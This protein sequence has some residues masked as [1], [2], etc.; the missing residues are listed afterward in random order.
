VLSLHDHAQG[1]CPLLGPALYVWVQGCP[2]RCPGC[3]NPGTL[4]FGRGRELPLESVVEAWTRAGP[5]LVLSG[6]EPFSQAAGLAALCRA[7][8]A[9]KRDTPVLVYSGFTLEELLVGDA[10]GIEL[11]REVDVL[12]DGPFVRELLCDHPLLGSANQRVFAFGERV[13][14]ARLEQLARPKLQVS[15]DRPGRLRLV[16]TGSRAVPL[17]SLAVTLARHGIKLRNHDAH[18]LGD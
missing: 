10:A 7:M 4:P 13:A 12:V 16:G 14:A 6:G 8:R 3:F 2:R 15:W 18:D 11:L 9:L 5:A 17:P 1:V